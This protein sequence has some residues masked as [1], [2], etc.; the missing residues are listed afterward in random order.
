MIDQIQFYPILKIN[1]GNFVLFHYNIT[2]LILDVFIFVQY[3][4]I[5]YNIYILMVN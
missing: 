2:T 1:F 4:H 5:F 3:K